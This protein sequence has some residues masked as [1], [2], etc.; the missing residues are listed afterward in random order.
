M[1]DLMTLGDLVFE[2][3]AVVPRHHHDVQEAFYVFEGSTTV[4]LGD[5]AFD[6]SAGDALLVPAG[7]SH[8]FRNHSGRPC[9]MVWAYAGLN[10]PTHFE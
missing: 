7:L 8:D 10:V 2:P 5:E 4:R 3:G 9:R 1:S 6:L